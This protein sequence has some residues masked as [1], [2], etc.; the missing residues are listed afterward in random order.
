LGWSFIT[1]FFQITLFD[2]NQADK[3]STINVLSYNVRIFNQWNWNSDKKSANK[4]I[5]FIKKNKPNILCIQEFYSKNSNGKNY[6]DSLLYHSTLKYSH[7]SYRSRKNKKGNNGIATFSSYPIIMQGNVKVD[8]DDNYCIYTDLVINSDT[9]RIYNIHL[10]SIHLEAKDHNLIDNIE[11]NDSLDVPGIKSIYW[12]FKKSYKKRALQVKSIVKHIDKC[13]FHVIICGDFNDTPVSYVYQQLTSNL[14]D[15]FKI[16]GNGVGYTYINRFRTFRIDY[17]LHSP[18]MKSFNFKVPHV[19]Y[20]DHF[21]VMCSF[22]SATL[23]S[24]KLK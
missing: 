15:A 24:K 22:S 14:D 13:P 1:R 6:E 10:E 11:N 3:Q 17:I 21:P 19:K 23:K 5:R 4:I 7:V 2:K 20:S 8:E 16:S 9:L 12:K 18:D